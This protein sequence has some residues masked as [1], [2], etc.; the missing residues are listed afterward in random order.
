LTPPDPQLKGAWY[1]GG[2]NPCTYQV[3]NR[4]QSLCLQNAT[5]TATFRWQIWFADTECTG[6][7]SECKLDQGEWEKCTSPRLITD[8]AEGEHNFRV[9]G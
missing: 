1:P 3:K 6:C 8:I 7:E 9:R 2:F 5:C 4:F